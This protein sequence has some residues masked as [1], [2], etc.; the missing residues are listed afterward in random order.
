M[1]KSQEDIT[2]HDVISAAEVRLLKDQLGNT[3]I[4]AAWAATVSPK[5]PHNHQNLKYTKYTEFAG[6]KHKEL[7]SWIVQPCKFFANKSNIV[8]D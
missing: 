4:L 2:P 1:G 3:W 8:H 7:L 6:S 5:T